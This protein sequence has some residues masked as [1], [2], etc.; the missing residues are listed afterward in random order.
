MPKKIVLILEQ[1]FL[2]GNVDKSYQMNAQDMLNVL[3]SKVGEEIK[4]SDLPKLQTI[5][6]WITKY[7]A[8]LHEKN[9]QMLESENWKGYF[10][11]QIL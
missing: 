5:Q 7:S 10:I 11:I 4:S 6:G 9:A 2:A 3:E 8:Q 1:C